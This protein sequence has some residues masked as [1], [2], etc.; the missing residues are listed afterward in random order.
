LL[1]SLSVIAPSPSRFEVRGRFAGFFRD[2][3]GKRRM[4]LRVEGDEL[5]LKVPRALR[6]ELEGRL[7][8]GQEVVV[9][10]CTEEH[11]RGERR[12]VTLV[13]TAGETGCVTCPIQVCA[14]KNC[15]RNG[16]KELYRELERQIGD[17]GLGDM[18][19]L[20]AVDCLDDCKH[21][22]N[23]EF[24]G[25]EFHRCTLHDAERILRQITG[26]SDPREHKNFEFGVAAGAFSSEDTL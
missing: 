8:P 18:V 14:K 25:S 10:G 6:H 11:P 21:G 19:R 16:G 12:V 4:V 26:A 23:A 1:L 24:A 2:I 7:Q 5:F 9:S 17:A 20:K 15:W 22:P 3:F 13:R